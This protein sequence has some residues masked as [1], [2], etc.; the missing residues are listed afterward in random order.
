MSARRREKISAAFPEIREHFREFAE[1]TNVPGLAF[2]IVVDGEL[3]YADALGVREIE[4]S[5]PVAADTVFR[6]ASM[7]K[8]FV[9][10]ALLKLR[11]ENK[12]RLDD[13]A[14]KYLPELKT[15]AYPTRD[16]AIIAARF[17]NHVARFSRRQSVGRPPNGNH[18]TRVYRVA[19]RGHSLFQRARSEIRIFQ[20]RV[21]AARAPHYA[22]RAYAFSTIHYARNF[23]ALENAANDVG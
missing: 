7:T 1:T 11:D 18:R 14:E 13:A 5:A 4:T 9:A 21:R 15:L 17:V 12:V 10:M 23:A 6:I 2:G 3:A 22:R 8:S 20:L 19:A 16:S